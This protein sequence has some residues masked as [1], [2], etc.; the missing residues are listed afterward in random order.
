MNYVPMIKFREI[1]EVSGKLVDAL[2]P[3]GWKVTFLS[4][5]VIHGW[6][7]IRLYIM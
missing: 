6:W 2:G 1:M 7:V 3:I 4:G 5:E